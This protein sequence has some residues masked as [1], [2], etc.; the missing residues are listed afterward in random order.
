[1]EIEREREMYSRC[2]VKVHSKGLVVLEEEEVV[3]F[4]AVV[5][6]PLN[7]RPLLRRDG[8]LGGGRDIISEPHR[9]PISY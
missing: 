7:R 1:M 4:M 9:Y 6:V 3:M 8:P 5:D 2:I